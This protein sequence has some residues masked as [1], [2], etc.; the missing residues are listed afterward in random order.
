M[1]QQCRGRQTRLSHG[2]YNEEYYIYT[3]CIALVC[4]VVYIVRLNSHTDPSFRPQHCIV[5][6]T[7][8]DIIV[9]PYNYSLEYMKS[10]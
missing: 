6:M 4:Y 3:V 5:I 10:I 7:V 8:L 1:G 2:I 9:P